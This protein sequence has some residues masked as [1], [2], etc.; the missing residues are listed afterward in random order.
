MTLNQINYAGLVES[1]R[2]NRIDEDVKSRANQENVRHNK[3]AEL[4]E[5][6]KN[7]QNYDLGQKNIRK[8]IQI[9]EINSDTARRN[10]DVNAQ[11]QRDNTT[12]SI[13]NA[14]EMA[15]LNAK[16]NKEVAKSK[17][18]NDLKVAKI[19]SKTQ[20]ANAKV[21]SDTQK[22]VARTQ[23]KAQKQVASISAAASKYASDNS[24]KGTQYSADTNLTG[25][26]F[27]SGVDKWIATQSKQARA[28]IK[29]ATAA[30]NSSL[31]NLKN[32]HT[33]EM[34]LAQ[35]KWYDNEIVLLKK[36]EQ[37]IA[38]RNASAAA[39]SAKAAMVNAKSN[40]TKATAEA[41][42]TGV[43]A[44]DKILKHLDN[45]RADLLELG[46]LLKLF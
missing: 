1:R 8:D 40:K 32:A 35:K 38:S 16:T 46:K 18:R 37:D 31:A 24:L 9:A 42:R 17:N 29:S 15:K 2:H 25:I 28:A 45:Y 39:K 6:I 5:R 21:Q 19:N 4:N 44:G 22:Q 12:A 27:K 10:A 20:K 30:V 33:N 13:T 36:L 34:S 26:K 14:S 41:I 11:T 43:E 7:E 3:M 23:T